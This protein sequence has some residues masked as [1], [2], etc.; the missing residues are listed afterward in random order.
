VRKLL[1]A[2]L[3]MI[4][5]ILVTISGKS[6]HKLDSADPQT[7]APRFSEE[8]LQEEAGKMFLKDPNPQ[9]TLAL[10]L[11][12][13]SHLT[14]SQQQALR[15]T[16]I[17]PQAAENQRAL[18]LQLLT[19]NK[20]VPAEIF[21]SIAKHDD[22]IYHQNITAHSVEE[23]RYRMVSAMIVAALNEIQTRAMESPPLITDL[24]IIA[25]HSPSGTVRL[26]AA[27]MAS[28][29]RSGKLF[30]AEIQ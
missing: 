7:P 2:I 1:A 9:H 29:V 18:A 24:E 21:V 4:G 8:W 25:A 28:A 6:S 15:D 19:L 17:N 16:V 30:M 3:L 14:S 26:I 23:S 22:P 12:V 20:G 5:V 11:D 27:R 13:A 10:R